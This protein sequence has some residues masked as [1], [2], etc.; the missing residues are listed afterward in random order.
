[1]PIKSETAKCRLVTSIR[2]EVLRSELLVVVLIG[3]RDIP[4][5]VDIESQ[6]FFRGTRHEGVDWVQFAT[7]LRS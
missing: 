3:G 6:S 5:G 4:L 2:S 7:P 1:M